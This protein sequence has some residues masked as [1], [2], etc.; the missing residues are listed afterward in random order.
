MTRIPPSSEPV[1]PPLAD[2]L[3]QYLQRQASAWTDGLARGDTT[4][5][6]VPFEAAPVQA[7]DPR[8][9]WNEAHEVLRFLH[10]DS[11]ARS[12]PAPA[13]WPAL[14][15][16]HEPASALAFCLGNFPQ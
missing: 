14:V 11:G 4:S 6:V 2:L 3:A 9:A 5:E 10:P 8:L 16:T 15:T 1:A 13:D 7:V 12:W